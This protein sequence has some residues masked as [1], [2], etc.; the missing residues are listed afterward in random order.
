MRN[1]R[2]KQIEM[3]TCMAEVDAIIKEENCATTLIATKVVIGQNVN[4]IMYA[5]TVSSHTAL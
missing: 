4:S 1:L 2:E 5:R 3:S